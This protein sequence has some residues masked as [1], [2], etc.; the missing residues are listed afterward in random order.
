MLR[1]ILK[2]IPTLL[3]LSVLLATLVISRASA[4]ATADQMYMHNYSTLRQ[5][6]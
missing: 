2:I 4:F 3:L 5:G 6:D 1:Q